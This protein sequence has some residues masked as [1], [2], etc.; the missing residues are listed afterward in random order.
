LTGFSIENSH[1]FQVLP[2]GIVFFE[3]R[4]DL[5]PLKQELSSLFRY[6]EI[7]DL[8]YAYAAIKDYIAL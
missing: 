2:L 7:E 1:F 4:H 8:L 3:I 6:F 5:C